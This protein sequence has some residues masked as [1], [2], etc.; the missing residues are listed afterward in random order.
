VT[1]GKLLTVEELAEALSVKPSWVSTKAAAGLIPSVKVG[2]YR[3]FELEAVL[4]R[5]RKA[6]PGKAA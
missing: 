3:R 4:E 6:E 2:R 5:L 1:A